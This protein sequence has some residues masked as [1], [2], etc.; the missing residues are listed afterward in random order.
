MISGSE[1]HLSSIGKQ[2][3]AEEVDKVCDCFSTAMASIKSEDAV[4]SK[5]SNIVSKWSQPSCE[6]DEDSQYISQIERKTVLRKSREI[7]LYIR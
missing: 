5:L 4:S 7:S 2:F 3:I 1:F 6:N